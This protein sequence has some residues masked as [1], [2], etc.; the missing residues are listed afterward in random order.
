MKNESAM[1]F[2]AL[3]TTSPTAS[4]EM[5]WAVKEVNTGR[6]KLIAPTAVAD[7][8]PDVSIGELK[9]IL[10]PLLIVKSDTVSVAESAISSLFMLKIDKPDKSAPPT[11]ELIILVEAA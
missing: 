11:A 4:R 10:P 9:T 5:V 2:V 8:I 1:T 3:R 7:K 6:L